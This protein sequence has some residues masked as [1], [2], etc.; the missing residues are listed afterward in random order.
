MS[1][2]IRE[3]R[4]DDSAGLSLVSKDG[5]GREQTRVV[6]TA[7]D[8]IDPDRKYQ[9]ETLRDGG[10]E[11]ESRCF[12]R[13]PNYIPR[14]EFTPLETWFEPIGIPELAGDAMK[15]LVSVSGTQPQVPQNVNPGQFF[16]QNAPMQG[17]PCYPGTDLP[18]VIALVGYRGVREISEFRGA[19]WEVGT[20]QGVQEEFFPRLW[21]ARQPDGM[22]PVQLRVIEHRVKE[23]SAGGLSAYGDDMLLSIEH[24]RRWATTRIGVENGLLQTRIS[25]QH[26][27]TYSKTALQLMAQLEVEPR[28]SGG[29][30]SRLAKEIVSALLAAQTVSAPAQPANI[31]EIVEQAVKAAL[32][33]QATPAIAASNADVTEFKCDNA[34]CEEVFDTQSGLNMH[35]SRW[36]KFKSE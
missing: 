14:C 27:Y 20:I 4:V 31:N 5:A 19:Q 1:A 30:T 21:G 36:C 7:L 17:L 23:V 12:R 34:P 11:V 22:L 6:W 35:K 26:T 32:L 13:T 3:L 9:I 8:V 2:Q 24:S 15:D 18:L 10:E 25:H 16:R 29:E 28:D 33:A